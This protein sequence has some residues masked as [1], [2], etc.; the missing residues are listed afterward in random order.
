M[1]DTLTQIEHELREALDD[2]IMH[3]APEPF[4][5]EDDHD[6]DRLG[7][8]VPEWIEQTQPITSLDV[9]AIAYGGC[10][11]GAYMPAV[12]YHTALGVMYRWG[13]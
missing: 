2:V 10:M 3:E 4:D 6:L 9:P 5:P 11:S 8:E 12:T 7:F 13:G 1:S